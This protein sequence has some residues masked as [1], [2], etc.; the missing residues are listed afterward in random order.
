MAT[1]EA[2]H[3]SEDAGVV[4]HSGA[5]IEV[6]CPADG[7][8]VG[9][10]P[11]LG[12]AGVAAAAAQLRAAQPAWEELGPTGRAT[13]M[14]NFLDWLLDNAD[15]LV[16]IMQEETGKSWG[17][18]ALEISMAVDLINDDSGHAAEFLADRKVAK[19]GSRWAHQEKLRGL[20]APLSARGSDHPVERPA[21]RSDARWCGSVD[22]RSRSAIQA[23]EFTPLTWAEASRGWLED[24]GAPPVLANVTGGP[25]TG[26]AVVEEVDMIMFT[27]S[28]HTGR[29]IAARAGVNDLIPCSLE[30]GGKDPMI[31][32]AD[33][34]LDLA[35]SGAV[36][37]AFTN[38]GQA[39][40]SVERLYVAQVAAKFTEPAPPRP[41][42]SRWGAAT[43]RIPRLAR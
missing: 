23:V 21:G 39:C 42:N 19:L 30:L 5:L 18:A 1:A 22:G 14:R 43:I 40:L 12:S 25:E 26:A 3:R 29:R 33:A 27:G 10:V 8:V 28:T 41:G 17:D 7:R 34:D 11:D 36:W 32:C 6:R 4:G 15:R 35:S 16:G 13:H 20:R 9:H 2:A 38:A 37:G 31:V 24:V